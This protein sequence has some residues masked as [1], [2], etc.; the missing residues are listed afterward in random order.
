MAVPNVVGTQTENPMAATRRNDSGEPPAR[1]QGPA[2]PHV[3]LKLK[4][5]RVCEV[6]Q[7][8]QATGEFDDTPNCPGSPQA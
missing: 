7:R 2:K 8:T 5:G 3:W 6:C 1:H 4:V